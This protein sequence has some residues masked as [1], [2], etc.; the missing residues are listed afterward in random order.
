MS[1]VLVQKKE[2]LRVKAAV[3]HRIAELARALVPLV[4]ADN[5]DPAPKY[6]LTFGRLELEFL[7]E[8]IA[9]ELD[10]MIERI[11]T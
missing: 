1:E 8:A 3:H 4:L 9:P 6:P 10:R 5:L 7:R 2:L 11:E